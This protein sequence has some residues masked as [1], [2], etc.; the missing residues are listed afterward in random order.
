M[1]ELAAMLKRLQ[2][3]MA[4]TTVVHLLNSTYISKVYEIQI[5]VTEQ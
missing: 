1:G 4:G 2:A 5:T 3:L